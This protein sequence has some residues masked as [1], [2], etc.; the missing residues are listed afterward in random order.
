MRDPSRPNLCPH[1]F[2]VVVC[3]TPDGWT[4]HTTPPACSLCPEGKV[5]RHFRLGGTPTPP[6]PP[7][8]EPVKCTRNERCILMDTHT[9]P[10][11]MVTV[12]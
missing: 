12:S 9:A 3:K 8:E 5:L 1:G 6:T 11:L 2:D 10:C 7:P 4:V